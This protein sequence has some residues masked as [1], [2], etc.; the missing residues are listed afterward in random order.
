MRGFSEHVTVQ[1]IYNLIFAEQWLFLVARPARDDRRCFLPQAARRYGRLPAVKH[2]SALRAVSLTRRN[3]AA[4]QRQSFSNHV[5][6]CQIWCGPYSN[7]AM[8][9]SSSMLF[10]NSR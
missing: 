3:P 4:V 7:E 1:T 10:A 9:M 2:G 6:F 5:A 8:P